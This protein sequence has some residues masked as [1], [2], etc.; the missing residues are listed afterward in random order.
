LR[1]GK[2]GSVVSEYFS[3]KRWKNPSF[4]PKPEE[5]RQAGLHKE[6]EEL[7]KRVVVSQRLLGNGTCKFLPGF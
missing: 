4:N 2:N 7:E 5:Q 3:V 6:I 1:Y